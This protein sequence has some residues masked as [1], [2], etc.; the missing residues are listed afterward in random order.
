[1]D[2]NKSLGLGILAVLVL[3]LVFV[4]GWVSSS[5]IIAHECRKLGAFYVSNTVFECRLK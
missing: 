4:V 5:N 3:L 2:G 1:M